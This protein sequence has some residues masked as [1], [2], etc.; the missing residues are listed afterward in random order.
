VGRRS[1]DGFVCLLSDCHGLLR[2]KFPRAHQVTDGVQD[3]FYRTLPHF[4]GV[5]DTIIVNK[6][7][8]QQT[9]GSNTK[10]QIS[11]MRLHDEEHTRMNQQRQERKLKAHRL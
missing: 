10:Q 3:K 1:G 2:Y 5:G 6:V 9:E 7:Q 8:K 11:G 4:V